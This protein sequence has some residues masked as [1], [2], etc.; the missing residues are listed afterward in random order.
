M[1]SAPPIFKRNETASEGPCTSVPPQLQTAPSVITMM[2]LNVRLWAWGPI[3]SHGPI[4]SS[5]T[6]LLP[7]T[8]LFPPKCIC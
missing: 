1:A 8:E 6:L 5:C 2:S 4:S 3:R 7:G